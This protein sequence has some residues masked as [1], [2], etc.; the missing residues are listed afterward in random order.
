MQ[1]P[2]KIQQQIRDN[3]KVVLSQEDWEDLFRD[4]I[5]NFSLAEYLEREVK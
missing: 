1:T 3:L 5:K 2:I 4:D